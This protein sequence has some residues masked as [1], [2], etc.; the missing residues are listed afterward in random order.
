MNCDQVLIPIACRF[1]ASDQWLTAQF[2]STW[3]ISEVK[4]FILAKVF[5]RSVANND[6]LSSRGRPVSPIT[7]ASARNS[8][9][10][11][12]DGSQED[13]PTADLESYFFMD[14]PRQ[15]RM[16]QTPNQRVTS[17]FAPESPTEHSA[18]TVLPA[19]QYTMLAFS[20]G[21]LLE[22]DYSLAWYRL[23]PHELL[24]LHPPRTIVRLQREVV[25]EYIKPYLELDVRALRVIVNDKD[26]H[27]L[28]PACASD[29][30]SPNRIRKAK[31]PGA[32]ESRSA[33][34]S[35]GAGAGMGGA[36]GPHATQ[37]MRKRRKTKLEW[38]DRHLV[39]RQGMLSLL[40]SRTD[41][42]PVHTC[43]LAMLTTLRGQEDMVHAATAPLPSPHIVCAKFRVEGC[44]SSVLEPQ[45]SSSPT[46]VEQW[47]DPWSGGTITREND[48]GLWGRRES[49]E[50]IKQQRKGA[51]E[52]GDRSRCNSNSIPR[53]D[54]CEGR[55]LDV[56]SE[57]L[58]YD[59]NVGDGTQGTWLVLDTL[60]EH[61]HSNLLRVLHRC[62][63]DKI[64]STL[65][66]NHLL[67]LSSL[68]SPSS[69]SSLLSSHAGTP[70]GSSCPYPEWRTEV[71]QRAQRSGLGNV[72]DAMS[73]ILR[74]GPP[75]EPSVPKL[76]STELRKKPSNLTADLEP[77]DF[78]GDDDCGDDGDCELEWDSWMRDLTRQ[79]LAGLNNNSTAT[80][81]TDPVTSHPNRHIRSTASSS[82][83]S[84]VAMSEQVAPTSP[85]SRR[86]SDIMPGA[87]MGLLSAD[88]PAL[89]T[90]PSVL[91]FQSTGVTTS[92][93]SAG[94]IVRTRSLISVDGG[95]GRGVARA[96]EVLSEDGSGG[97]SICSHRESRHRRARE[98]SNRGAV[99][100]SA[101]ARSMAVPTAANTITST[102][103][104]QESGASPPTT[105][106]DGSLFL[107]EG[108]IRPATAAAASSSASASSSAMLAGAGLSEAMTSGIA[109]M[110][111]TTSRKT[112]QLSPRRSSASGEMLRSE[113]NPAG[114]GKAKSSSRGKAFSPERLVSKLDSALD[115]VSG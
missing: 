44:P 103:T 111:T 97:K 105:R 114:K 86:P 79:A 38:R 45:L 113:A 99:A 106:S 58:W 5:N 36:G 63:P 18:A 54:S 51:I 29:A 17:S 67:P 42:T 11:N 76:S 33:C 2:D 1:V 48:S 96:M 43:S 93:V 82:T 53:E 92:T 80:A 50:D 98:D 47:N 61:A 8:S 72:S 14:P 21:Q 91:P 30:P 84:S 57:S 110:T 52:G 16:R 68:S 28:G 59:I 37:S 108:S 70:R 75:L 3:K 39:I 74:G 32:G 31:D 22:D 90:A 9:D 10:S 78:D 115:F 25:L 73:W 71:S 109:T 26:S 102:V 94:G 81:V 65:V 4:Q 107:A 100:S 35:V 49:K 23:R 88:S 69:P 87:N 95:R 34:A 64:S 41:P 12:H 55:T 112:I 89:L 24:E 85:M 7:F 56:K 15:L 77:F 46:M 6:C 20:T 101:P 62:S 60:N 40:K 66:P 13:D 19:H 83:F 104:V 27:A